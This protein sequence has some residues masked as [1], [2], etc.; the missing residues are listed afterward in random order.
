M[1]RGL[2]LIEIIIV[3]AIVG[4]LTVILSAVIAPRVMNSSRDTAVFNMLRQCSISLNIYRA[5]HDSAYPGSWFELGFTRK[6]L[7]KYVALGA[8]PVIGDPPSFPHSWIDPV[9]PMKG[10]PAE[11]VLTTSF[12]PSIGY[13][14]QIPYQRA[15][16]KFKP[17][18]P[19]EESKDAMFIA[20]FRKKVVP[21]PQ[22]ITV[23]SGPEKRAV[24]VEATP[25]LSPMITAEGAA[26]WGKPDEI[27]GAWRREVDWYRWFINPNAFN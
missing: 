11:P 26:K 21:A 24:S 10:K 23:F 8:D 7:P 12:K 18:Y 19:F 2:T 14:M 9:P 16:R 17:D 15:L 27:H 22:F 20:S 6:N 5:D 3:V 25:A 1:K 13:V 4:L